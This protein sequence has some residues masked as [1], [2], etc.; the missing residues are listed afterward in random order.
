MKLKGENV[1]RGME[2]SQNEILLIQLQMIPA[3]ENIEAFKGTGV[4]PQ[5][6]A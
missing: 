6:E 1:S 4:S 2:D 5:G 3:G